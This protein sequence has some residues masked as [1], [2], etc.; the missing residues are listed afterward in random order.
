M[1]QK[2]SEPMKPTLR[3][4]VAIPFLPL[5]IM[6]ALIKWLSSKLYDAVVEAL[7]ETFKA[8]GIWE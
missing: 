8:L 7:A 4:I 6:L 3:V 5:L 2:E 1:T